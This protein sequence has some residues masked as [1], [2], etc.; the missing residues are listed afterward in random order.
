MAF[1]PINLTLDYPFLPM[2]YNAGVWGQL[3]TQPIQNFVPANVWVRF[4]IEVHPNVPNGYYEVYIDDAYVGQVD[5]GQYD[6]G[7][8][9]FHFREA[10]GGNVDYLTDGYF[11]NLLVAGMEWTPTDVGP[12]DRHEAVPARTLLLQPRRTRSTPKRRFISTCTA[13]HR[14]AWSSSTFAAAWCARWCRRRSRPR[15]TP[16]RGM[17]ATTPA[18]GCRAAPN[19][20]LAD[21][22]SGAVAHDGAAEVAPAADHRS[23]TRAPTHRPCSS[24]HGRCRFWSWN[25]PAPQRSSVWRPHHG[26]Y[27]QASL[28]IVEQGGRGMDRRIAARMVGEEGMRAGVSGG[29][30]GDGDGESVGVVA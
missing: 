10:S 4:R 23:H 8:R 1:G 12:S 25:L 20:P 9:G 24:E 15:G 5:Y 18:A 19:L 14:C 11:D 3:G 22:G 21:T 26:R 27:S 13:R 29:V 30:L 28:Q 16:S 17:G 6:A 7:Y 2:Q